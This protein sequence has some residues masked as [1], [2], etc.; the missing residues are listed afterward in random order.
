MHRLVII[1]F[2]FLSLPACGDQEKE[3]VYPDLALR[4]PPE[5]PRSTI[6][7]KVFYR[8]AA[9]KT[10]ESGVCQGSGKPVMDQSI[11]VSDDGG[12]ADVLIHIKS[13]LEN[14]TFDYN[15][16]EAVIDQAD[17]VFVPHVLAVQAFQ[18]IRIKNSD[19][20][21]HNVNFGS[22]KGQGFVTTLTPSSRARL[23]QLQQPE[24]GIRVTCGVHAYMLM[25]VHVLPHPF[26]AVSDNTGDFEIRDLPPGDYVV[27]ARHPIL[28]TREKQLSIKAGESVPHLQF[29]FSR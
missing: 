16:R 5:G 14:W 8:G 20:I 22:R 17:C 3:P 24:L 29:T 9:P 18:P 26:F 25:Y 11:R 27:E 4:L 21:I 23:L 2:V 13:G 28:G 19:R 7:G 12:L 1:L 10:R 15:R 6:S